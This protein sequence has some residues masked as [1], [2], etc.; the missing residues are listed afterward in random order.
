MK[1]KFIDDISANTLQVIINQCCG[2]GIFYVLSTYLNKNDFGEINW[3]LA[4]LLTIYGILACGIDQVSVKKVASGDDAKQILSVYLSHVVLWGL[5]VYGLLLG[6]ELFFP[7]FFQKHYLL[8]LLAVAKLMFFFSTPFKQLATGLEKF[9]PLLYMSVCSNIARSAALLLLAGLQ[10]L[11]LTA[12]VIIFIAGDLAELLVCIFVTKSI[13]KIPVILRW[14]TTAY[15]A[16]LKESL[17]QLGVAI[18]T[19]VIARF[20]WIFLGLFAGNIIVA[21]YSFAYKVF[22]MATLPMLIIAPLLIPRFTKIFHP[23][24]SIAVDKSNDLLVL[25]RIEMMVAS[26]TALVLNILWVPVI[27]LITAGKYGAVNHY[28]ILILSASMPFLYLNNFLWTVNF[29]KGRLKMIFY[30][31]AFTFC[32]NIIA[33][34]ILIPLYKAEGAAAGYLLAIIGQSIFYL[35]QTKLAGLGKSSFSVLLCPAAAIAGGLAASRLFNNVWAI[36][37][38]AVPIFI[39]LLILTKQLRR[40]DLQVLRRV[41]GLQGQP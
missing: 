1:G 22:E 31:F 17:P 34:I 8:L 5:L 41:T 16:L 32:I 27:D 23:S 25:L 40:N 14:N 30:N 36:L 7:S 29:A 4:V 2:L 6:G 35:Y 33:D 12:I 10:Q 26:F 20:D 21:E 13:I 37:F 11:N 28:S 18:F 19:S 3:S 24:A 9:R 15:S 38:T 39:F